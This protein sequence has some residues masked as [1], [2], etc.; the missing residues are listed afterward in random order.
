MALRSKTLAKDKSLVGEKLRAPNQ[1]VSTL[2]SSPVN[3][4]RSIEIEP[5]ALASLAA[6]AAAALAVLEVGFIIRRLFS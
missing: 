3:L 1:S 6:L 2:M 5:A 4:P